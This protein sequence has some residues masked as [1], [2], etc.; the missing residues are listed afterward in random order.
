MKSK[1]KLLVL[2]EENIYDRKGSFNAFLGRTKHLKNICKDDIEVL[3]LSTYEPFIIRKIRHTTKRERPN[4]IEIDG[5]RMKLDWKCF[6][7]VDYIL[8]VKLHCSA[9][10]A[11]RYYSKVA[12]SLKGYDLIIAHS[13]SCARIAMQVKQMYGTPYT[14][15]WHGSDI[16]SAPFNNAS[17]KEETIQIIEDADMNIF[18]SKA[19]QQT[20][21]SLTTKGAKTVLYNG[22]DK[23]FKRYPDE[24]RTQLRKK[25]GVADKKVVVFV[26]GFVSVKNILKIPIIFKNIYRRYK[27]LDFWMIG[28]GKFRHQVESLS[29]GLPIRF[30]GNQPTE[31]MPDYLNSSDVLILPSKNEGLPLSVVEGLA[32]G[33]NV[34]GSYVGGIPEV[35]GADNC[36]P[37]DD[38]QFEE[39]IADKVLRYLIADEPITQIL[40]PSFDW[41]KTAENELKIIDSILH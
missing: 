3:I 15:T 7:L 6:S 13:F 14:V 32:C 12:K 34:V 38:T 27:N 36:V 5:I 8:S 37:P 41:D 9:F 1:K 33:C 30:F 20:S 17:C 31:L 39:H 22:Y 40:D 11:P 16:H 18:V 35:I 10:F 25:Y 19:L 24:K 2:T 28:D 4:A 23:R 29:T 21:D 26:G